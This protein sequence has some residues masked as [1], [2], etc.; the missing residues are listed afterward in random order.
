MGPPGA[1]LRHPRQRSGPRQEPLM[2]GTPCS[3]PVRS[4]G[5][6]VDKDKA[7]PKGD[8]EVKRALH[9]DRHHF[10]YVPASH[11]F[12]TSCQS[13]SIDHATAA[14]VYKQCLSAL[15]SRNSAKG[16]PD[17]DK[18]C[19]TSTRKRSAGGDSAGEI[20]EGLRRGLARGVL[21]RPLAAGVLKEV[22]ER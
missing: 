19:K 11:G 21:F 5:K 13:I 7:L 17:F 15:P 12:V 4:E 1:R 2:E 18:I 8:V 14:F 9:Q 16:L 22:G 6:L 20:L 3:A 10:L